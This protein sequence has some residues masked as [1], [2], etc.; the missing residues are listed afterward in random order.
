MQKLSLVLIASAAFTV[1]T[2]AGCSSVPKLTTKD[3]RLNEIVNDH[4]EASLKL[5]PLF[6]TSIGD[7]RYDNM[8]TIPISETERVKSAALTDD[9]LKKIRALGCD[10][11]NEQDTLT[12]NTFISDLEAVQE[13]E[14]DDLSYLMPFNQFDS[15]FSNFAELA[16]GASYVT[17]D[18]ETDYNNFLSRL[19]VVPAYIDTMINNMKLGMKKQITTPRI[20][21]EKANKQVQDLLPSD[22]KQSVFYK[23]LLTLNQKVK[24]PAAASIRDRYEAM[25]KDKIYPAYRKLEEFTRKEYKPAAR[26]THGVLAISGGRK[27]YRALVRLHTTL[28]M[29]PN[30]IMQLGLNEVARITKQLE[31]VKTQLGFKGTLKDFFKSIRNDPKLF[32]FKTSEEVLAAYRKIYDTVWK[33]VPMHYRLLPK[34]KFEVR[35]VEKFKAESASEAYQ[36]A[37]PDGSR[38]G[39]FWVPI[40]HPEKYGKK[41]MESLFLHE[42]MPGHHFQISIQQELTDLPK[43]RRFEGNNAYVEGWGLYSESMGKDLGVYTDPYQWIGRL[44]NDMHRAIRLVVDV[45]MHWKGWTRERAIQYSL[46]NE[47]ADE[48]GIVSEIERYLVIPGQALSYKIGEQKILELKALARQKLGS[49]YD[50]RDFHDQILKDGALPLGVLDLKIK[51]WLEAATATKN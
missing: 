11:L 51:Q 1:F 42:A 19:A 8:L 32:P 24:G 30:D 41:D 5:D 28:N 43:Y 18:N 4:F 39:I 26:L 25:I 7:H 3:R 21:V 14:K 31:E 44:E 15:F 6:A 37:S 17:F 20:L 9:S 35:E 34:A 2:V 33:N 36:N 27:F 29:D 23:P 13:L 47:P 22:F 10:T 40:P 48:A 16:S 12:C 46:D 50:D 49:K 38:P 45:G